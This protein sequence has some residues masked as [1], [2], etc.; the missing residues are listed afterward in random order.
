MVV[1]DAFCQV[2][3]SQGYVDAKTENAWQH[4]FP[5]R[6]S[7]VA[8]QIGP[9]HIFVTMLFTSILLLLCLQT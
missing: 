5:K 8:K 1:F 3:G 2:I 9:R 7:T 6:Q 4:P